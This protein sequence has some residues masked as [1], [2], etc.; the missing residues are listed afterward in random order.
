MYCPECRS[1]YR[2]G[3][4]V[5][6][7]CGVDLVTAL[8]PEEP[9]SGEDPFCS[10]WKG[11]DPRIHAELRGLL[12]G[13]GIATQTV[14][15]EDHLFNRSERTA[16]ELGVPYSVYEKAEQIV[17]E[18]YGSAED[19]EGFA[20]L[21][22][23]GKNRDTEPQTFP[24]VESQKRQLRE[25]VEQLRGAR[26]G[27]VEQAS[28]VEESGEGAPISRPWDPDDWY[29]ED[30][31]ARVWSGGEEEMAEMIQASLLM[32]EIHCRI[33]GEVGAQWEVLVQPQDEPRAREIV[34]QI[35]E[36]V[37]PA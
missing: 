5:C 13:A 20:N 17:R 21:L 18:A 6:S 9:G 27:E 31:T 29:S 34:R 8:P 14:R 22:P 10:F 23:P 1:E 11:D 25:T 30:A 32:N 12:E 35:V 2:K 4:T 15:R 36:G 24:P 33:E 19:P 3:V 26:S 16:F 37:P 28:S 7:D